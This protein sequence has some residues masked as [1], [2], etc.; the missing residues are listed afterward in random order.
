[1]DDDVWDDDAD[2][3]AVEARH[4]RAELAQI[5]GSVAKVRALTRVTSGR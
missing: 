4:Q 1:M 3:R 2:A 5:K